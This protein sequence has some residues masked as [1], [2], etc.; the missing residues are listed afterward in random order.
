MEASEIKQPVKQTATKSSVLAAVVALIGLAD[1]AYLTAKHFN[2]TKVPCS[3]VSGCETVLTSSYAEFYGIPTAAFGVLAYLLAFSLA[4]LTAFGSRGLWNLFG[5]LTVIMTAFTLWL[6][7]LQAFVIGAFCQF[8][9][10]SAATTITL[11]TIY[12]ISRLAGAKI[13]Q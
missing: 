7:Y 3:I 11:F 9:L 12:V 4:L 10:I 8:C 13:S 6:I 1:S 5:A 2:G